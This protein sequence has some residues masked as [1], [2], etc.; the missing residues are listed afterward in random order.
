MGFLRDDYIS[1]WERTYHVAHPAPTHEYSLRFHDV[2]K[3]AHAATGLRAVVLI[4]EYDKPLLD[5]L[6][7]GITLERSGERITLEE[8]NRELLRT[9]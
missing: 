5:I 3:A 7:S 9:L 8:Y 6:D 1:E 4:D 2:L